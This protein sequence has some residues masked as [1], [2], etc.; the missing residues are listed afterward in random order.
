LN[1]ANKPKNENKKKD[2]TSSDSDQSDVEEDTGPATTITLEGDIEMQE[3]VE[4]KSPKVEVRKKEKRP[5]KKRKIEKVDEP[6]NNGQAYP[7]EDMI[8]DIPTREPQEVSTGT[9]HVKKHVETDSPVLIPSFPMP[10]QPPPASRAQLTL[11]GMDSAMLGAEIVEPGLTEGLSKEGGVAT[12][13]STRMLKR[14]GE[15]GITELFAGE[16]NWIPS[17]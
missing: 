12:R 4:R 14:L 15:L 13:L 9:E 17:G 5:K 11:Q 10:V 3:G 7:Q 1:N 6:E 8:V 2:N 16:F